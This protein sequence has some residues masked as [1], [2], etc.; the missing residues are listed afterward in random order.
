MK[1]LLTQ[2]EVEIPAGVEVKY[3]SRIVEVKGPLGTLKKDFT[4]SSFDVVQLT[5]KKTKRVKTLRLQM[6]LAKRR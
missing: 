5:D 6:W 2:E 3:R 4:H 1:T